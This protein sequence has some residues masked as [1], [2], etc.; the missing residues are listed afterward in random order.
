MQLSSLTTERYIND[1]CF[2]KEWIKENNIELISY[3]DLPKK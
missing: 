3:L 2:I 1:N